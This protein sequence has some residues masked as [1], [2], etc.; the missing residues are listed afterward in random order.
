VRLA[1]P[2]R[3]IIGINP[4]GGH[5]EPDVLERAAPASS[6]KSVSTALRI[7]NEFVTSHEPFGV[8]ELANRLG[9]AKGQVSKILGTFRD[10]GFLDQD[11][12]TRKYTV[13]LNSFALGNNFVNFNRLSREALSIMRKLV[14]ETGH[15]AVLSVLR[16]SRV[17]HL[18]AVEGRLF[19]D[20]RWRVGQWMHYHTT[21]AGRVLLAFGPPGMLESLLASSGL[22]A[23]TPNSVTDREQFRTS[24]GAV[25]QKGFS[26]T[27]G[28][29]RIGTGSIAVPL[30]DGGDHAVAAL[31]LICPVHLL[32]SEE[33][34]R[35]V[36]PLHRSAREL[37]AR[38]G[39]PVYPC[40]T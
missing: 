39:A 10:H 11:P 4:T 3:P 7:L 29:M 24:I 27:R 2:P 5:G 8:V 17:I 12:S 32:R 1:R 19:L 25:R 9:L 15:S 37:S 35:L 33:E 28:E 18:L 34:E 21:S 38:L 23:I 26:V 31:G 6:I 40:G 36:Y 16:G 20:G 30:F 22:P 13:G 14:D